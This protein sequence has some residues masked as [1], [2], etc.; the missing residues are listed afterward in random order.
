MQRL[1]QYDLAGM[2]L[3]SGEW[4]ELSLPAIATDEVTVIFRL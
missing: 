4:H 2:L 1:Q 3:E